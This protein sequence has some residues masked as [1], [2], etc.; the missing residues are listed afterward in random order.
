MLGV[1]DYWMHFECQHHD[2][3]HVHG[4]AWLPNA[5]DVEQLLSSPDTLDAVKEEVIVNADRIVSTC[6]PA[7]LPDGSNVD[8]APPA[9]TDSHVCN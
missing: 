9:R 2:S 5:P 3:P 7:I 4:L 6:N 8:D 1:T